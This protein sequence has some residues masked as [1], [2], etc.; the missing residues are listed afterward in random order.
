MISPVASVG[1]GVMMIG[2]NLLIVAVAP[3]IAGASRPFKS[4]NITSQCDGVSLSMVRVLQSQESPHADLTP[5]A[6]GR[7]PLI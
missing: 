3:L 4:K 1:S 2:A 5:I 7:S 6:G